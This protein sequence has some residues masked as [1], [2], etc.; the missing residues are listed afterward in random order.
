MG[1]ILGIF[2]KILSLCLIRA[3]VPSPTRHAPILVF[4]GW[5]V[6]AG[7][8][9]IEGHSSEVLSTRICC[10]RDFLNYQW[11]ICA[12]SIGHKQY[13]YPR[14]RVF[15]TLRMLLD[16]CRARMCSLGIRSCMPISLIVESHCTAK[17]Y[18]YCL[19]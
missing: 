11:V 18:T 13:F 8:S 15:F 2:K 3:W 1:R 4:A 5:A 17:L 16:G 7:P 6:V 9:I 10:F 19:A 12:L 14:G